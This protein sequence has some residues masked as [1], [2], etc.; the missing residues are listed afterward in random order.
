M[1]YYVNYIFFPSI[2]IFPLKLYCQQIAFGLSRSRRRWRI[3]A[4]AG[5]TLQAGHAVAEPDGIRMTAGNFSLEPRQ[6][7]D[8]RLR[9]CRFLLRSFCQF[10]HF[11]ERIAKILNFASNLTNMLFGFLTTERTIRPCPSDGSICIPSF[12]DIQEKQFLV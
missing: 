6:T 1:R 12:S 7:A 11:P 5:G 4:V 10:S 2:F 8:M 3:V 9:R